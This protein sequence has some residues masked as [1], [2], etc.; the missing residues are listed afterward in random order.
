VIPVRPVATLLGISA[1]GL[2]ALAASPLAAILLGGV[3]VV[4]GVAIRVRGDRA[5][6]AGIAATGAALFAAAVLVLVLAD[7]GQDEPVI[8]GPDTGLTPGRP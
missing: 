6:G 1:V 8:L 4:A 3:L 5:I 7:A 2:V